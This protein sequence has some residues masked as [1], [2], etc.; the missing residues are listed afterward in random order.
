MVGKTKNLALRFHSLRAIAL[1]FL[2]VPYA[3]VVR[4]DHSQEFVVIIME[5]RASGASLIGISTL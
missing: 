2:S 1:V 3:S 4:N 5:L